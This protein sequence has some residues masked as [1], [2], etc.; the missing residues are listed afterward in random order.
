MRFPGKSWSEIRPSLFIVLL[1]D[2]RGEVFALLPS[3]RVISRIAPTPHLSLFPIPRAITRSAP[4]RSQP[5]RIS[6]LEKICDR[7]KCRGESCIRPYA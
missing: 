4:T 2:R 1:S 6:F 3:P 5:I 7:D